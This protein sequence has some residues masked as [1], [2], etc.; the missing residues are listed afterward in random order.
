MK[1]L[2]ICLA[3]A[4]LALWFAQLLKGLGVLWA[5]AQMKEMQPSCQA[6]TV[7][8]TP[9]PTPGAEDAAAAG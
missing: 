9:V 2:H 7:S 8:A 3:I 5:G 4:P 1:C 6:V